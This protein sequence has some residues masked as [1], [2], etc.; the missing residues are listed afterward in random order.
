MGHPPGKLTPQARD[1][2]IAAI[3]GWRVAQEEREAAIVAAL[4]SGA[5]LRQVHEV[6]GISTSRIKQI[7]NAGGW[8]AADWH[9]ARAREKADRDEW[10]RQ[11]AAAER[12]LRSGKPKP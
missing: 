3:A 7:G 2:L 4:K 12:R 11:I 10:A 1:R 6:T 9:A 8:S 5:S